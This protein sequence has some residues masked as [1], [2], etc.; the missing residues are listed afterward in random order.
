MELQAGDLVSVQSNSH[1]ETVVVL[2]LSGPYSMCNSNGEEW[3]IE[4]KG[5]NVK[6]DRLFNVS[7]RYH[8]LV[9]IS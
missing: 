3:W 1:P 7:E 6:T 8:K 4:W 5:K 9:K 2:I